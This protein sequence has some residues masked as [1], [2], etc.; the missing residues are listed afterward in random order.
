MDSGAKSSAEQADDLI[1]AAASASISDKTV[2]MYHEKASGIVPQEVMDAGQSA[3]DTCYLLN[4]IEHFPFLR[5]ELK[6]TSEI[7][8]EYIS[9]AQQ[10]IGKELSKE[11]RLD[12]LTMLTYIQCQRGVLD[13]M[14]KRKVEDKV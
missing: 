10:K 5:E 7:L 12:L 1:A 13:G 6:R 3:L 4:T 9:R 2:Q 11:E 8:K 14:L